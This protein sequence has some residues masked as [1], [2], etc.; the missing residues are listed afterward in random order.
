MRVVRTEGVPLEVSRKATA[1]GD[2]GILARGSV[3]TLAGSLSQA[4]FGMLL[5]IGL[6][7][8]LGTAGA[9]RFLEV[10]AIFNIA[11]ATATLG[12]DTGFIRAISRS[13][14]MERPRDIRPTLWVGYVP[15]L[16]GGLTLGAVVALNADNLTSL[17]A[18]PGDAD[19]VAMMLRVMA[20][21]VPF[22]ALLLAT[23]GGTRAFETM[24]PT[25]LID[26]VGKIGAQAILVGLALLIGLSDVEL[27][28]VWGIPVVV[29]MVVALFWLHRLS[30]TSLAIGSRGVVAMRKLFPEFWAFTLPRTFASIF[31][32]AVLWLDVLLVGILISPAAAG[33]YG[34][35]TRL[36]QLGIAVAFAVGQVSQPM[37][38]RLLVESGKQETNALYET[39]TAWQ[40]VVT[41]PQYLVLGIFSTS[42]LSLFGP[43]FTEGNAVVVVLAA[44]AMVGSASG[45]ADSV[46]LMAGK[47]MWSF[48]NT[49]FALGIN[50]ALNLVLIPQIGIVGAAVA[51][52]A[53]RV[54]GNVLPLVQLKSGLAL[55]PF[56]S[57]WIRAALLSLV[58]FGAGGLIVRET[59]VPSIASTLG[60]LAVASLFYAG[61]LYRWRVELELDTAF[62]AFR[63]S[64]AP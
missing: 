41:W 60:F 10:V 11:A 34:I 32:V 45:P 31:R 40:M 61:M 27:V 19:E 62:T 50:V 58:V 36:L 23:L 21:F 24:A 33:I 13:L 54:I 37:I 43:G 48:W 18:G 59:V 56:G 35:S 49:A 3:I 47:S 28:V 15:V 63:S 1:R 6:G 55:H 2:V 46:L 4:V 42:I 17:L 25:V 30:R 38:S 16:V 26:R 12:V 51:W 5:L 52:A 9:G 44:S 64:V 39:A 29:A 14:A 20:V 7:R 53:S 8:F 57:K 22:G